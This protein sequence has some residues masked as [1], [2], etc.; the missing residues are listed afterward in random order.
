MTKIGK[1]IKSD[2]MRMPDD[3]FEPL[4]FGELEIN[5]K[6][7]ILPSPGDNI[8][9]GGFRGAYQL[10]VKTAQSSVHYPRAF[11]AK[12]IKNNFEIAFSSK[13]LVILVE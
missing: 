8:G 3:H 1:L 2:W 9:H 4:T 6:F 7:I 5:Q 13:M 11:T 12:N 10:F